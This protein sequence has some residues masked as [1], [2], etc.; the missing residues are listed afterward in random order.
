MDGYAWLF[1]NNPWETI[2]ASVLETMLP[3]SLQNETE[4]N[5]EP[6]SQQYQM[7]FED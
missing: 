3:K 1:L 2:S 5:E 7:N 4:K 6:C